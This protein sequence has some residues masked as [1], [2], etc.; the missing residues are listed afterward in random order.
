MFI[1]WIYL[2]YSSIQN[3][4]KSKIYN[5]EKENDIK[6]GNDDRPNIEEKI[7]ILN[8]AKHLENIKK[9]RYLESLHNVHNDIKIEEGNKIIYQDGEIKP[10]NILNGGLYK[11]WLLDDW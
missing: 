10:F 7:D 11:N 3:I 8:I 9:M 1:T 2:F 5:L 6:I 4:N